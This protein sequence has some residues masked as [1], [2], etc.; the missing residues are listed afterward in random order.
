MDNLYLDL[1]NPNPSSFLEINYKI[2]SFP[3]GQKT[4]DILQDPSSRIGGKK[5][6][7]MFNPKYVSGVTISSRMNSM[8]DV[9][10]IVCANQALRELGAKKVSL[11]VPYFLGARSDRKFVEGGI[12]FL[13]TVICPIINSQKFDAVNVMDPHS[14]VLEACLNNFHKVTNVKLV[15][16]ALNDYMSTYPVGKDKVVLVSPDAGALKKVFHVAEELHFKNE[17][18]IASKHRDLVSGKITRTDV[19]LNETHKGKDFFILDDICDGGR[20]FIE[21]AKVLHKEQPES[22][23]Y[24]VVTHGIFSAGFRE[25]SQYFDGI[26]CTNSIK[27]IESKVLEEFFDL[28]GKPESALVETKVKQLKVF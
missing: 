17:I 22:K 14:D 5:L 2:S 15:D 27:N 16:F 3:D 19:P 26:Y 20:T 18:V 6:S 24:L 9:G 4:I 25:L 1:T 11:Y 8:E 12:N 21:I 13:K 10:L 28:E 7:G 23:V